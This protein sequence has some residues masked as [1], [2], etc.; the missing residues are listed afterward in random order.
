MLSVR[1][2]VSCFV[3]ALGLSAIIFFA[4]NRNE[5]GIDL[6]STSFAERAFMQNITASQVVDIIAQVDHPEKLVNGGEAEQLPLILMADI[7]I[8][9]NA[10]TLEIIE[11]LLQAGADINGGV[12]QGVTPFTQA[13]LSYIENSGELAMLE[14]LLRQ[15]AKPELVGESELPLLSLLIFHKGA[16]SIEALKLLLQYGVNIEATD[17]NGNTALMYARD[18]ELANFLLKA[19]ANFMARN[20][21]GKNVLMH[22]ANVNRDPVLWE[23]MDKEPA[24]ME[25]A[26]ELVKLYLGLGLD[27]E[28][29]DVQEIAKSALGY[30]YFYKIGKK[31][32]KKPSL[33]TKF[34][35]TYIESDYTIGITNLPLLLNHHYMQ[36]ATALQIDRLAINGANLNVRNVA[37]QT[38]LMIAA[39]YNNR[40]IINTLIRRGADIRVKDYRGNPITLP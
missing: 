11:L 18:L 29:Q 14:L 9:G 21:F 30:S 37:G 38:P 1:S 12:S 3:C 34:L 19:G 5:S 31:S 10:D 26:L 2:I 36:D 35:Q 4:F 8:A 20:D 39:L 7:G 6:D 25:M 28:K 33:I 32:V 15:G 40:S 23:F 16:E 27:P 24:D 13:I 17:V 22:A